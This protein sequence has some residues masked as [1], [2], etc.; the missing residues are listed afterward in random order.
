M[1]NLSVFFVFFLALL[2]Q[3]LFGQGLDRNPLTPQL[4]NFDK[5]PLLDGNVIPSEKSMVD[6]G[7]LL[8]PK[9]A[10]CD[11]GILLPAINDDIDPGIIAKSWRSQDY[12]P[13]ERII[14]P[15]VSP[16]QPSYHSFNKL[17]PLTEPG[18]F[19]NLPHPDL[20]DIT[21]PHFYLDKGFH[22]VLPS[23]DLEKW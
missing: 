1:K 11:P 9:N 22:G 21:P 7:I 16:L 13:H 3:I 20:L 19:L 4:Y 10:N 23:L 15:R 2:P 12:T 8:M 6:P 18:I 5:Y 17:Q 14:L